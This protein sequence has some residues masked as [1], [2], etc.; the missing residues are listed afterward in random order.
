MRLLPLGHPHLGQGAARPQSGPHP[1]RDRPGPG[2]QSVPLRRAQSGAGCRGPG[3]PAHASE[4]PVRRRV[5][6]IPPMLAANPRLD[7]WVSFEADGRVRLAFGRVEYGQGVGTSLA[8]MAADEL[9]V[10][11]ERLR[12]VP[13][14]TG[15]VPDEG[16]TVGSMSTE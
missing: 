2:R 11:F 7:S 15:A 13:V 6:M 5:R 9:D 8:Q 16:L 12:I 3:R 4:V 1:R 10:P 14:A